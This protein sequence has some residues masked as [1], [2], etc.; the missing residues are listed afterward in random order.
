MGA[1]APPGAT[2]HSSPSLLLMGYGSVC[3]TP[4]LGKMPLKSVKIL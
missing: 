3:I 4:L 2:L 1:L